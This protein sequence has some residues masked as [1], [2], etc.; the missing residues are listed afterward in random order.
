M[1]IFFRKA[2]VVNKEILQ[3]KLEPGFQ[4]EEML[5]MLAVRD[6]RVHEL[7]IKLQKEKQDK[8]NL[9]LDF[10]HLLDQIKGMGHNLIIRDEPVMVCG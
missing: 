2:K 7:E 9:E 6:R 1:V 10:L 5:E 4:V 3:L 8:A